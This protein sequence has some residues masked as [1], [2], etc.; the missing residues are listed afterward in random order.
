MHALKV[1]LI[2]GPSRSGK[3][4]VEL[5]WSKS[6][7]CYAGG[8]AQDIYVAATRLIGETGYPDGDTL[9][10]VGMGEQPRFEKYMSEICQ[11]RFGDLAKP[12]TYT[13]PGLVFDLPD[14]QRLLPGTRVISVERAPEDLR[15]AILLKAFKKGNLFSYFLPDID[16]YIERYNHHLEAFAKA[17][18]DRFTTVGLEEMVRNA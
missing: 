16:W 4:S 3:T 13:L 6:A 2:L 9:G 7:R 5:H 12:V 8:E 11:R 14:I 1:S 15:V 17:F 18:P 10:L